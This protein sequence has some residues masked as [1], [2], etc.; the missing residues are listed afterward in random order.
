LSV[1]PNRPDW[2]SILG[3]A[4]EVAAV[5][6][7]TVREPSL[8]FKA[9]G[10]PI[11]GNCAVDIADPDLCRRYVGTVIRDVTIAPSPTWMQER[12]ISAG[13]RPINNIVDITNYVMLEIGQPLHAFDYDKVAGHHIIVRRAIDGERF[14]TLDGI[15]RQL[16]DDMLVIADDS[17]AVALAGVIGGLDSEVTDGTTNILLEAA[18]FV[19]PNIRRTSTTLKTR[20]EAST[21]FEKGLPQELAMLG[22]LRATKLLVEICGGTALAGA[23]DAYPVPQEHPRVEVSRERIMQVLGVDPSKEKVIGALAG[24]GFDVDARD[25]FYAAT[26]PYWRT[27]VHIADDLCEEIAR[28]IGYDQIPALPL[29]AAIPER[30]SQPRR[31]LRERTRDVLAAAGMRETISYAMTTMDALERVVPKETL[32]T[33]PPLK[34]LNP[35]SSEHEFLRPTLRASILMTLAPNLRFRK[36][37]VAIFE[38]AK[39]YERTEPGT[40]GEDVHEGASALPVERE[41][42][43]AA[44]TGKRLDR[45]GRPSSESVDFFDAKAYAEDLLR[46]LNIRGEY[47]PV[48]EFGMVPG[49]AAEI[50]AGGSRIGTIGQVHPDVCA[51][52]DIGQEVFLF[53]VILDDALT[54]AGGQRKASSV[55]R[56]PAVEQDLAL[57]VDSATPAGDLQAA[58]EA[59]PLVVEAKVFD[60]YAGDQVPKGRKS[61]AFSVQYQAPDRTLTDDDVAKAQR[62]IVERLKRDFGADLRA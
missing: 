57:V 24:L 49:R 54:H 36:G 33:Y 32:A 55:S 44:I 22:S 34:L 48:T 4:R 61:I 21:R 46:Q 3:V 23:A 20:T 31:D 62:K 16:T 35:I 5:T 47:A 52:F 19:G 38:T 10:G 17:D 7:A 42:V 56:F 41:V 26:A 60:V 12:L 14:T 25:G 37:E 28:I 2:L 13:Q 58:I 15:E 18:N 53:E 50:I 59:A 11:Q 9:A 8:D 1:T 27:D 39:T 40:H 6:R 29:S 43:C 45:W 51:A 30:V